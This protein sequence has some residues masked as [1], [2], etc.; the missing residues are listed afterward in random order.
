MIG[1]IIIAT[2]GY[3]AAL[4]FAIAGVVSIYRANQAGRRRDHAGLQR[5][6]RAF[7]AAVALSLTLASVTRLLTG[8]VL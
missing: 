5:C 2:V 7:T 3:G 8:G 6:V 4:L 1:L